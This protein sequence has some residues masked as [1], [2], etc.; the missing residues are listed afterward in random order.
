MQRFD[1][2]GA[3]PEDGDRET[4]E[5]ISDIIGQIYDCVLDP[6]RWPATLGE[7]VRLSGFVDGG[8]GITP[9]RESGTGQALVFTYG[10]DE[11]WLAVLGDYNRDAVALWGS[12]EQIQRYPLG[13]P[14]LGSQSPAYATRFGNRY[15]ADIL[16]PRRLEEAVVIIIAREPTL[17][18]YAGFNKHEAGLSEAALGNLRLIAPH[19][20]RAVTI[21]N[22]FDLRA[23]GAQDFASALDAMKVGV[24]LVDEE[25]GL[26]HANPA[27]ERMI[28]EGDVLRAQQKRL[29]VRPAVSDNALKD[30]VAH[31]ADSGVALG[32]KGIGIPIRRADGRIGMIH[33]MPLRQVDRQRGTRGR[34]VA[35]LFVLSGEAPPDFPAAALAMAYDLT[36]AEAR[37]FESVGQGRTLPEIA[38]QLGVAPSTVRTHLVRVFSKTGCK[39]QAE[40]VSL[41]ARFALPF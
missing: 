35:A 34:A 7:I 13:E 30:A 11:D 6:G 21:S 5:R 24:V 15:Y 1:Q 20:R 40:L 12:P 38:V 37:V 8:L 23:V 29:S 3:R 14:I 9:W 32:Q 25:M 17:M 10:V 22:L 39:R 26:V 28:A 19:I 41:A 31:A 4:V 18:A 16:K 27:A 33:V 2:A 36:P